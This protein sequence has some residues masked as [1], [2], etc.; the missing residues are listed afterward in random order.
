MFAKPDTATTDKE[1]ARMPQTEAPELLKP[2]LLAP[3]LM[4]YL[5]RRIAQH[6]KYFSRRLPL[7]LRRR[8]GKEK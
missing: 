2:L 8:T 1:T 4:D 7:E 5:E 3:E 6:Q